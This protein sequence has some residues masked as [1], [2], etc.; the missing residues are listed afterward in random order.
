M[1]E[2]LTDERVVVVAGGGGCLLKVPATCWCI[3]EKGS[4][5]TTGGAATLRYKLHIK[6]PISSTHSLLTSDQPVQA[7]T[8]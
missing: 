4:V 2:P 7:L 3:S 5:K 6:L 8:L 1:A